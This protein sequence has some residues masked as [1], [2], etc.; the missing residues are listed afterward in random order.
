MGLNTVLRYRAGCDIIYPLFILHQYARECIIFTFLFCF[1][2]G[3]IKAYAKASLANKRAWRLRFIFVLHIFSAGTGT[4][5]F[6]FV[7]F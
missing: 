2:V 7:K 1:H 4:E 3:Q 5:L 6:L